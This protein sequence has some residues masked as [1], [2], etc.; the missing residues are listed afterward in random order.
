MPAYNPLLG[1]SPYV[2]MPN[3]ANPSAAAPAVATGALGASS[4]AVGP[5][6]VHITLAGML[7]GAMVLIVLIHLAGFRTHFTIGA[8]E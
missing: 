2:Q 3:G 7:L 1:G 4:A 8:G 5:S 6:G